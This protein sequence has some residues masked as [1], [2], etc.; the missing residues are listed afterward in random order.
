MTQEEKDRL[1]HTSKF[2]SLEIGMG[3]IAEEFEG[4]EKRVTLIERLIK[5]FLIFFLSTNLSL[6][7]HI[8]YKITQ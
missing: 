6:L 5:W 2:L 3:R 1:L 8:I 4:L 7:L